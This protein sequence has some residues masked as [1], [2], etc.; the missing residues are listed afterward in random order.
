MVLPLQSTSPYPCGMDQALACP[1]RSAASSDVPL[2][3][4]SCP[5]W[6]SADRETVPSHGEAVVGKAV[7][8]GQWSVVRIFAESAKFAAKFLGIREPLD[9]LGADWRS[10]WPSART[11][12]SA[13][14]WVSAAW[15]RGRLEAAPAPAAASLK[16]SPRPPNLRSGVPLRRNIRRSAPHRDHDYL[17]GR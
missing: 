3:R 2:V 15:H 9:P 11:G 14:G 10:R 16:S 13:C 5:Q 4:R 8:S 17:R 6:H 7:V 12:R 1:G